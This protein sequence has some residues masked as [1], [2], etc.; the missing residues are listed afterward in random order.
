MPGD[1]RAQLRVV[2][3]RVHPDLFAADPDARAVN[4]ESLKV[5]KRTIS[6]RPYPGL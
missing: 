5:R 3:K 2:I 4:A 6:A 1:P